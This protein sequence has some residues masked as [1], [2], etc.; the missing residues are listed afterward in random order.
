MGAFA[1]G[2][3]QSR[4]YFEGQVYEDVLEES[5]NEEWSRLAKEEGSDVELPFLPQEYDAILRSFYIMELRRMERASSGPVRVGTSGMLQKICVLFGFCVL[6]LWL[7][8]LWV[9]SLVDA[10]LLIVGHEC[11]AWR[12]E[13]GGTSPQACLEAALRTNDCSGEGKP[14]IMYPAP[15]IHGMEECRCCETDLEPHQPL[16]GQ[17]NENW[18]IYMYSNN[19]NHNYSVTASLAITMASIATFVALGFLVWAELHGQ[20]PWLALFGTTAA[21]FTIWILAS[22]L[23]QHTRNCR[24]G[25]WYRHFCISVAQLWVIVVFVGILF[26]AATAY[27]IQNRIKPFLL[28][29]MCRR[30]VGSTWWWRIRRE[31][32]S[33][34]HTILHS[35]L[36]DGWFSSNRFFFGYMGRRDPVGRPHGLGTWFDNSP[37]GEALDGFWVRGVPAGKFRSREHGTNATFMQRP[38]AYICCRDDCRPGNLDNIHLWP[39]IAEFP[40]YGIVQ[41]EISVAGGFFPFLPKVRFDSEQNSLAEM[42]A[43]YKVEDQ[44]KDF[45]GMHWVAE[46]DHHDHH[47]HHPEQPF[48]IN[49]V[50]GGAW[51]SMPLSPRGS[52]EHRME[53]LVFV[54]GL[55][56]NL[57]QPC[58]KLGLLLS[59]GKCQ[60]HIL[61]LVFGWGCGNIVMYPVV[62]NYSLQYADQLGQFFQELGSQLSS[63][64][65][66]AHSAGADLWLRCFPFIQNKFRLSQRDGGRSRS[67]S[68]QRIPSTKASSWGAM[69]Y[70]SD[71]SGDDRGSLQLAN[72]IFLNGDVTVESMVETLPLMM[73]CTDRFTSY[74]DSRD[75]ATT[76]GTYI[77]RLMPRSCQQGWRD[78]DLDCRTETWGRRTMP[79]W[80]E[81]DPFAP[82]VEGVPHPL[83]LRGPVVS[84][85]MPHVDLL[86]DKCPP[87]GED[88]YIDIVDCTHIDTN[89][90]IDRHSYFAINALL[91]ED[92][93]ECISEK[94]PARSRAHLIKRHG[95]VY[96][97]LA[98]PSVIR[99]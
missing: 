66:I 26:L 78:P 82:S 58:E 4:D 42:L 93:C 15:A 99:M 2:C 81:P 14:V 44:V 92:I 80:L 18:D 86:F 56:T 84:E 25:L 12:E 65:V 61:P 70:R 96:D 33:D 9:D 31:P 46:H 34:D 13:L 20:W 37:H 62:K 54:H 47:D 53:A 16:I 39:N 8:Y 35:Y 77:Q 22:P 76:A 95:N 24:G 94:T 27:V 75:V 38:V 17:A 43:Q 91:V 28:V 1:L 63:V 51:S 29:L 67:T 30:G 5:E 21:V 97:F 60:P 48:P 52:L 72:V 79:V 59:L 11:S 32:P 73:R 23:I 7:T 45:P 85:V 40:T 50:H 83:V 6:V 74:N 88:H 10:E 41:V 71:A 19:Y 57:S 90:N 98:A 68:Q 36:P 87:H 89:I 3:P 49:T 64:H 55:G 69:S